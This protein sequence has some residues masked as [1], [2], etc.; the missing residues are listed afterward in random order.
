[1]PEDYG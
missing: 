1:L